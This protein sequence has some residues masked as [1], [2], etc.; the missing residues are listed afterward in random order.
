MP[1]PLRKA[2]RNLI[3]K[4]QKFNLILRSQK[5]FDFFSAAF[6]NQYITA[7]KGRERQLEDT[8]YFKSYYLPK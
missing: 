7:R 1:Y 3:L 5:K 6:L 2:L 8:R 4:S